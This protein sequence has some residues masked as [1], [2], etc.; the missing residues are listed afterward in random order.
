MTPRRRVGLLAGQSISESG[1]TITHEGRPLT[2]LPALGQFAGVVSELRTQLRLL[3]D[4]PG[5]AP[6]T[7]RLHYVPNYAIARL[8]DLA[9]ARIVGPRLSPF[10]LGHLAAKASQ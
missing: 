1:P 5:A 3:P 8:C 2:A 7:R 6:Q 4:A 9:A 10:G